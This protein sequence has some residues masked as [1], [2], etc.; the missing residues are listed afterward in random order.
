MVGGNITNCPVQTT[1]KKFNHTKFLV[2]T[3]T[4]KSNKTNGIVQTTTK[5]YMLNLLWH[6]LK[7][8]KQ[9]EMTMLNIS[10]TKTV[11]ADYDLGDPE[12]RVLFPSRTEYLYKQRQSYVHVCFSIYTKIQNI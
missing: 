11:S 7:T 3:T 6:T 9:N 12:Y 1:T 5:T 10:C 2:Q 8:I 4:T